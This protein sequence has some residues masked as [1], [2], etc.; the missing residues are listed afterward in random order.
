ML[1]KATKPSLSR[2]L[3][4]VVLAIGALV[5]VGCA[6]APSR[7]WSGP[8]VSDN[9]LYVG[10]LKGFI[11]ALDL[12]TASS[13]DGVALRWDPKLVAEPTSGSGFSCGRV[14]SAMGIYG[15]PVV[16]DGRIYVGAYS[17]EVVWISTD[18]SSRSNSSFEAAGDIVG[19]IVIAGE[20]LY[21][22]SSGGTLYA[23]DLNLNEKWRFETKGEIWS[24]PV[25]ADN[26]VYIAS[27]DH[28]LYAIDAESGNEIWR[29]ETKA[30]IMSTPLLANGRVYIGGCDRKFYDIHAES[31]NEIWRFETKAAIMST[32]LLANGRVYIGGCD[33]KFYD[34]EAARE[35][36]RVAARDGAMPTT[37]QA[38]RVFGG[39]SNWFCTQALA[40]DGEIWVGSL[41]HSIYVLNAGTLELV[42][43]IE[44][45]GMVYAP[46]VLFPREGLVVV[47][48]QDGKIYAIN[49]ETKDVSVYAI[50]AETEEVVASP[51]KP[52]NR[53]PPILAPL[54]ADIV[55]G[56]VYFHSQDG[57]HTLYAFKLSTQEVLWS[58]RTDKISD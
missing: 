25:V 44:T 57:T 12:T 31:G 22:G 45:G 52:K 36:E 26:V 35:E 2:I 47:G 14:S 4:L 28:Y 58:F 11:V 8:L 9:V 33:R 51:E 7:G 55:N 40:Y 5:A 10:T 37:R 34:I 18:G 32:P 54:Y 27:A 13:S 15:T 41:D 46:P 21:F 19:S 30:A 43:E 53:L 50:D 38:D 6:G 23:L 39:A 3:L 56:I 17:G 1:S 24:T 48:S 49:A 16:K 29:F 42:T 20:T